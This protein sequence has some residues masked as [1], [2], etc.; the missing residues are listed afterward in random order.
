M[1]YPGGKNKSGVYQTIINQM[2]PHR[3]Y[4]EAFLGGGAIMRMKRPAMASIGIDSDARAIAEFMNQPDLVSTKLIVAD[5]LVFLANIHFCGDDLVYLDP[6]YLM[7]TRS[8]QRPI[9]RHE[10]NTEDEHA[11]LLALIKR[12]PCMVMISGYYSDL[13]AEALRGWR[14]I[15]YQTVTRGATVVTEWLWMNYPE[16][17]ELHDYRYVGRNFRARERIKRKTNRWKARLAKMNSIER[18][19]MMMAIEE[20]RSPTSLNSTMLDPIAKSDD[21]R[22]SSLLAILT[23]ASPEMGVGARAPTPINDDGGRHR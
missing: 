9:Y 10:F 16:P 5:A 13:Y 21:P 19:A 7:S 14:T 2:P 15:S 11:E 22:G 20:L 12:L 17:L 4:I 6:P 23:Y 18:A 8:S 1:T 3:T